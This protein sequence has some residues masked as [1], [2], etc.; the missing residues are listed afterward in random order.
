MI[1]ILF[2]GNHI[3]SKNSR[4]LSGICQEYFEHWDSIRNLIAFPNPEPSQALATTS[5]LK[6]EALRVFRNSKISK[7]SMI[8]RI[9]MELWDFYTLYDF[10]EFP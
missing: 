2:L 8:S 1:S 9:F 10:Y 5:F 3:V 6:L 4:N 7:I